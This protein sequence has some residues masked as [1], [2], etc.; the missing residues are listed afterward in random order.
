E[1]SIETVE[2][3]FGKIRLKRSVRPDAPDY[4]KPEHDDVRA[5]AERAGVPLRVVE[6]A[7][8]RA[9]WDRSG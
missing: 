8:L 6:Q 1:R 3:P 7:A 2:T 5:A 4:F 9:A